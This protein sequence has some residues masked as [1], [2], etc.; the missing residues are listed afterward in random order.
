MRG[1]AG[2]RLDRDAR[3]PA[4]DHHARPPAGRPGHGGQAAA[5]ARIAL[6]KGWHNYLC[7]HKI[8]GGYPADE[9]TLFD[10]PTGGERAGVAEHPRRERPRARRPWANR[11]SGCASGRR[12][13][14]PETGTTWSRVCRTR[15]GARSPSRRS[16]A[17]GQVPAPR[18]LL[19]RPGT[20]HRA[21]GRRRRDQPRH[22]RDRR[23][24][25]ARSPARAR[26][27]RGRR[28]ARAQ[29]PRHRRCD[30][31][32]LSPHHRARRSPRAPSRGVQTTDLDLAI[33]AFGTVV[34]SLP[35]ERFPDGLPDDARS[36]VAAV[37]D[38]ARTVLSALSRTRPA[39]RR[40]SPTPG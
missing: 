9:P 22:A 25:L 23:L 26:R 16:S 27:R 2:D 21:G 28:G 29:R 14:R 39:D 5:R 40:P 4:S 6:L 3:A 13:P 30:G 19:P 31:R 24:G 10:L 36:V 32:P 18:R 8:A 15:P 35:A 37:R 12:R 1:R 11:S 17:W 20:H 33:G 7:Q 34:A 38:A